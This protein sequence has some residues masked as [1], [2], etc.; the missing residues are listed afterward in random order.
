MFTELKRKGH[1]VIV[2]AEGA[3]TGV[4]DLSSLK[5]M[6]TTDESGNKKLSVKSRIFRTLARF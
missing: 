5:E 2:V 6:V 1:M 3:G 4:Q